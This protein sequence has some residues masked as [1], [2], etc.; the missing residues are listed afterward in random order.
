[1]VDLRMTSK[2]VSCGALMVAVANILAN[3]MKRVAAMP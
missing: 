1:M 2:L 3:S